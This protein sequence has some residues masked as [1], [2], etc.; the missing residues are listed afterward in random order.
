MKAN[1]SKL[2]R[3]ISEKFS[4][5]GKK[6][7]CNLKSHRAPNLFGFCFPLCWRC[8]SIVIGTL[9]GHIIYHQ[10]YYNKS[11]QWVGIVLMIP[12]IIDSYLQYGLD[13]ESTNFRR[14]I[15][16]LLTGFGLSYL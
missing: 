4:Y 14:I 12:L 13:L 15:T 5:I 6:P 3:F 16:G 11:L 10:N 8:T 1:T 9:A 2:I 7:L